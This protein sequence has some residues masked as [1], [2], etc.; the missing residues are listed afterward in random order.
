M[1]TCADSDVALETV[2]IEIASTMGDL[3]GVGKQRHVKAEAI[4]DPAPLQRFEHAVTIAKAPARIGA[5]RAT[6]PKRWEQEERH[7]VVTKRRLNLR[8]ERHDPVFA[9]DRHMLNDVQLKGVGAVS[10]RVIG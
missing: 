3:A 8:T 10:L 9:Q 1:K 2:E 6:A 5:K 4:R 7:V